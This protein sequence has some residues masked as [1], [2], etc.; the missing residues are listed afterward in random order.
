MYKFLKNILLLQ[1]E[2]NDT[3]AFFLMLAVNSAYKPNLQA[4]RNPQTKKRICFLTNRGK[5]VYVR[6]GNIS[7]FSFK[8]LASFGYIPGIQKVW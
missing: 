5:S 2:Q 1:N 3:F 8:D 4:K 6:F 7:R